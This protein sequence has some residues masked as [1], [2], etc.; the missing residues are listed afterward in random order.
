MAGKSKSGGGKGGGGHVRSAKSGQYVKKSEAK[1]HPDSTVTER[2]K[3][4]TK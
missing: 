4:R 1:K 3:K 2:D